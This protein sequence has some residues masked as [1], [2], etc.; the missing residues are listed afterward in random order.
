LQ[1]LDIGLADRQHADPRRHPLLGVFEVEPEFVAE[2]L[3][4]E[5]HVF[6]RDGDVFDSLDLHVALQDLVMA[7]LDPAV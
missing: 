4:H 1:Q 3:R 7:G 6:D 2:Q 5:V